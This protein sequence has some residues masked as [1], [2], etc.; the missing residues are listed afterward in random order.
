[1]CNLPPRLE[2]K[3]HLKMR[4]KHLRSLLHKGHLSL[5][6]QQGLKA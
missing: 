1:M 2:L 5:G 4:P 6:S 3:P